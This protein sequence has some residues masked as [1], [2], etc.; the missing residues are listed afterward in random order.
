M[1]AEICMWLMLLSVGKHWG[2]LTSEDDI[3]RVF[4]TNPCT[5]VFLNLFPFDIHVKNV[6]FVWEILWSFAS[7]GDI[8]W[9]WPNVKLRLSSIFKEIEVVF[10]FQSCWGLLPV[11]VSLL[12]L[13]SPRNVFFC[14]NIEIEVVFH[15][16]RSWGCFSF[17][18]K[19]RLSLIF[20]EIEVVF[21][22]HRNWGSLS[23]PNT[24]RSSSSSRWFTW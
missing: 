22:F 12:G 23:F 13:H 24:L 16:Q 14:V 9:S 10:H 18:K 6:A 2:P 15:F 17:S 21:H 3:T 8:A 11:P 7:T 1:V 20:K 4:A 5:V 19:L